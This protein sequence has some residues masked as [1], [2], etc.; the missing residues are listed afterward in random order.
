MRRMSMTFLLA[1]LSAP[2]AALAQQKL[3]TVTVEASAIKASQIPVKTIF[4]RPEFTQMSLSPNGEK[5]MAI[6]PYKG[7]NNLVVIDL[8]KRS[9]NII[10][11]YESMDV[12]NFY[13]VNN[14]RV[15]FRVADGQEVTGRFN[16]RG[17][18][19]VDTDGTDLR[20]FTKLGVRVSGESSGGF[21]NITPVVAVGPDSPEYIVQM[22]ERAR[23]SQD[24]YQFNTK[25]GRY[26][27]LT[28]DSPGRVTNWVLDRNKVPRVAVRSEER[29]GNQTYT[30]RTVW[31]RDGEGAK[32]EKIFEYKV[33]WS[34][35][36]GDIYRPIAFDYDNTTLYV[37]TNQGRDTEAVYKYDTKTKKLGELVFEHPWLDIDGGL[38]FSAAQKK[39]MGVRYQA[40]KASVKWFDADMDKLQKQLD[41]TFKGMVNNIGVA[42]EKT[43]RLLITSYSD[44]QPVEYALFDNE[45]KTIESLVKTREW[46]DPALMPERRFVRFKAR[47]GLEIPAW[48]T[49]PRG[50]PAKNLPLIVNIHGGPHVRVYTGNPWG[51]PEAIFFATRGYVVIEPE[52]RGSVGF[53]RKHYE[54]S[55]KQWGLTMQ[56]DITDAAMYL[57][58]EGLVDKNRMCLHGGSYGGYATLQGLVKDPDLWK[59]GTPFVAVSD[60]FLLQ[61][62]GWS[63]I[64]QGSDALS[65]EFTAVVGD[66]KKDYDQFMLTSPSKNVA[67]IKAPILIAMGSDD[68]R[69][70]LIH[71]EEFVGNMRAAGKK[72]DFVVYKGE[73]H[74][75]NKDEHVLDF[76]ERIEKFYAE[77]LKK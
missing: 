43:K 20:D 75:F 10:T 72:V 50:V 11:A 26:K 24:I 34:Q 33:S 61:N 5:L 21:S 45:A 9:R 27:L 16:Y 4:R 57:V 31:H 12:A 18:Y 25:T 55:F 29:V 65:T 51:R 15:C 28:F 44:T 66:S 2:L 13:W 56:D 47:D 38:I 39:L 14:S 69:V 68:V 73:G 49:I 76:Y 23:D 7:R 71:A 67:K 70:P 42:E 62:V 36:L 60:L 35:G 59:C 17:T 48:V 40:D 32:W 53:G 22:N 6:S 54:S 58:K 30:V 1:T 46:L 41:L 3:E 52:P 64:A 37:A 8:G 19:C 63:D 74:G 77:N